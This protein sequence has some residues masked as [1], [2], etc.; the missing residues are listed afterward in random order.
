MKEPK[1]AA[2]DIE[3]AKEFPNNSHWRKFAPLGITCAAVAFSDGK[4]TRFWQGVPFMTKDECISL[5]EYLVSLTESGYQ[6]LTWNGC[7]FDFAVLAYETG[8]NEECGNLALN[9]TDLMLRITFEK[10]Y[11][12]GLEKALSG[13]G[14]EGKKKKIILNDGTEIYDMDGSK[15]PNLWKKGEYDAVLSYLREDVEQLIKLAAV[16]IKTG[17]IK[18][19]SSNGKPQ[20]IVMKS[21]PPVKECFKLPP[22][23][24][25]WMKNPPHRQDFVSWIPDWEKII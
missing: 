23:D 3:I 22:A 7:S 2:F 21:F 1:F 13:A 24:T 15:A 18:W 11:F 14:L 5:L 8:N 12:L 17:K 25:S 20:Q 9:H 19:A 4:E 6:I 16:I 10:G